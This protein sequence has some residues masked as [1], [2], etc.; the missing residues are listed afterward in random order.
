MKNFR[1]IGLLTAILCVIIFSSCKSSKQYTDSEANPSLPK[2][3]NPTYESYQIQT[4]KGYD[5]SFEL[6]QINH[7]PSEVILFGI[8]K[9][10][11]PTDIHNK[12]IKVNMIR[13]TQKL[14][15]Y[16]V[17]YTDLPNGVIFEIDGTKYLKPTT[18]KNLKQ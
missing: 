6:N 17:N 11:Q 5:I 2:I 10:I 13:E 8:R 9:A 14:Q 15:G 16:S 7:Q 3:I 4:E 12:K 18:F 1:I